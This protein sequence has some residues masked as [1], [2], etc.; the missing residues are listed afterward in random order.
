MTGGL[1]QALIGL[2][3]GAVALVAVLLLL[4]GWRL[5]RSDALSE[6]DVTDLALLRQQQVGRGGP[7]G[8]LSRLGARLV[9]TLRAA[10]GP[11]GLRWLN[12]QVALAGR[13]DGATVDTVLAN[14]GLWIVI[15]LPVIVLFVLQAQVLGL[16]MCLAVIVILPLSRLARA[17]RLRR[18][19]LDR[20][21]PD[22]L[23]ILSVTVAA[24]VGFRP[25]LARV[26]GRFGGPLAEEMTLTLNQIS[27]GASRRSA[28]EDLRRRTDSEPMSQFV[29]AFLQAE[30]LGAP[31][32]ESLRQI[33]LDMR[34]VSAQQMR[35]RAART[36]PRVTL[37]TSLV[38]VPASI[39]LVLSGVFV[40][41][42]FDL[43]SLIGVGG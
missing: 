16:V 1:V 2:V 32:V 40:A 15:L 29:T 42:G 36:A 17:R 14:A 27:N 12:Q 41:S 4:R 19:R 18:E 28:F 31:I 20:D 39:V 35:R 25:A 26:A 21:L 11:S 34:R 23:D 7:L 8:P 9:P 30:E 22:F 3:P 13:P 33:A 24:G 38:L 37:V 10:I 5:M 6:L 43:D